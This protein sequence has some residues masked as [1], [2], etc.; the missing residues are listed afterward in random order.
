[1]KRE[2]L[3][4]VLAVSLAFSTWV[5]EPAFAT[6]TNPEK[7]LKEIQQDKKKAK[8]DLNKTQAELNE[9][10]KKLQALEEQVGKLDEQIASHTKK[11]L[12]NQ[13]LLEKQDKQFK[14]TLV[15]MYQK[16]E[17]D[18]TAQLLASDSFSEFLTRYE[19][20]RVILKRERA[21]LEGYIETKNKIEKEKAA[22]EAKKEKQAPILKAAQ[23]EYQSIKSVLAKQT[24][25]LE[26]LEHQEELTKEAIEEKNRL[27]REANGMYSGR[28]TGVLQ[29]PAN[30]KVTSGYGW[31]SGRMHE[32]IDVAN[33]IGTPIYAADSGTVSLTKSNP[34]GYGYYVVINHGNG[35]STLYAHMYRSTVTVSVGDKV[36]KGQRIASIGNNGRSSG[37]HLHF[38]VHKNGN[39][40]DPMKYLP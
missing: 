39:P 8:T 40:V 4:G 2:L 9:K 18:Y 23:K 26:K 19:T 10:K 12:D 35:L 21:I 11:L 38:E 29:W 7:K 5:A 36:R 3:V 22:V 32:G 6:G 20:L 31:R 13:K 24:N 27:V 28:G 15:R 1:M 37:P 34:G 14:E 17:L 25:N 30:G 16:N 33:S